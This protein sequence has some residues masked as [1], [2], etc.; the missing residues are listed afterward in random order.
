M[1]EDELSLDDDAMKSIE[2][3]SMKLPSE[4]AKA[5]FRKIKEGS[6][7]EGIKQILLFA[8]KEICSELISKIPLGSKLAK[9]LFNALSDVLSK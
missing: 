1:D 3:I 4:D 9:D 6:I 2:Q 7:N 5:A 8:G